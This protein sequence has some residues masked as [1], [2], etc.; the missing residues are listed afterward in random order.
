MKS[1]LIILYTIILCSCV[2]T[3]PDEELTMT[4]TSYNGKEIRLDGCYVSEPGELKN[5]EYV[6]FYSNGVVFIWGDLLYLQN[7]EQF[8]GGVKYN[9]KSNWGLFNVKTNTIEVQ[10]WKMSDV[11]IQFLVQKRLYKIIND[12]TLS[13]DILNNG[14]TKRYT[15]RKFSPKPDSTNVF[16]K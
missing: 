14:Y 12:S 10:K 15:F 11:A 9:R 3:L 13:C 7:L 16:I 4:K 8:T 5:Y 2:K 1:K 6:F